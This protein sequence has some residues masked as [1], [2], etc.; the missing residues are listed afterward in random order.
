[1]QCLL[2]SGGTLEQFIANVYCPLI[3]EFGIYFIAGNVLLYGAGPFAI[4]E[5]RGITSYSISRAIKYAIAGIIYVPFVYHAIVYLGSLGL[6]YRFF[7]INIMSLILF[8]PLIYLLFNFLIRITRWA[9]G[10]RIDQ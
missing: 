5:V 3:E 9:T 1:M 4:L 7:N 10:V 2:P 6:P 8:L